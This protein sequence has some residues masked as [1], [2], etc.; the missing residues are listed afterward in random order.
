L[1][2]T[3][4]AVGASVLPP[5]PIDM[6]TKDEAA[7][8]VSDRT[9]LSEADSKRLMDA[10]LTAVEKEA[11][12][13]IVGDNPVPSALND[14]RALRLR[15][16]A[17]ELGRSLRQREVEAIFRLAPSTASNVVGKMNATYS[18]LNERLQKASLKELLADD[19]NIE[20]TGSAGA[21][22]RYVISVDERAQGEYAGA[23]LVRKGLARHILKRTARTLEIDKDVGGKDS[24]ELLREWVN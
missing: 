14:A 3:L 17:E 24:L 23:L 4:V 5:N 11:I 20:E 22:W 19:T 2:R 9:G 7:A 6:A 1:D 18:T 13:L 8:I 21:G 16:V 10:L 12:D 15:Y